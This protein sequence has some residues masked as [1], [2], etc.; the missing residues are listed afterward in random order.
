[1]IGKKLTK[2]KEKKK[3]ILLMFQKRI[4]I[5]RNKLFFQLF[6]TEKNDDIIL[7]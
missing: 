1:M 3:N 6:Q 4:Q 5:V 2:V 7:Q